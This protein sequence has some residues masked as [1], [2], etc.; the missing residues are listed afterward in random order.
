MATDLREGTTCCYALQ[1]KVWVDDPD[2]VVHGKIYTVLADSSDEGG[3]TTVRLV[4]DPCAGARI[5]DSTAGAALLLTKDPEPSATLGLARRTFAEFLGTAFLAAVVIG[6]GIAAEQLSPDAVGLELLEDALVTGAGLVAI[7]YM[8]D[9]AL[10]R[11]S[12]PSGLH[13][14]C[15]PRSDQV[16]GGLCLRAGPGSRVRRRGR[17]RESCM[18]SHAAITDLN[19]GPRASGAHFLSELMATPALLLLIFALA[20]SGRTFRAFR[21]R[22]GAYIAA[23]YFFTSSTSFANPAI[24]VGR[25]FSNTFA[26]IAPSSVRLAAQLVAVESPLRRHPGPVPELPRRG[27]ADM[28]DKPLSSS[29]APTMQAGAWPPRCCSTTTPRAGWSFFRRV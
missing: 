24:T 4:G 21:Q 1:D 11:P 7:I 6:S 18:F 3:S 23:A 29:S 9:G 25:M 16:A 5:E 14:R 15:L 2:L 12:Q 13:C 20:R 28:N 22:S 26:G 10:R 8:L 19:E 17:R 27:G